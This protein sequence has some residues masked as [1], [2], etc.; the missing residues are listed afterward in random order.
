MSFLLL[1]LVS[2]GGLAADRPN[3]LFIVT[4][5]QA[6]WATGV[7]DPHHNA[8]TPHMDRLMRTGARLTNVHADTPVCSPARTTLMTGQYGSEFGI[9]DWIHPR[10]EKELGVPPDVVMWPELLQEAG[11]Y[12]GLVGKWHLGI[13]DRHHPTNNGFDYFM[14]H[15]AGGWSTEDPRLE[16]N[17]EYQ[18]FKGLNTD[19]L[20]DHVMNF[21][22]RADKKDAPFLM[23]WHKRAPPG[24]WLP[25]S[26]ADW[27]PY[28]DPYDPVIPNPDYP[29]LDVERV[30][31]S[32][33]EYLASVRGVDR[34]M[35]RVMDLLE[36]RGM[37]ENTVVIFLS[38]HGYNVGHH[39]IFYKGNAFWMLNEVPPSATENVPD[40]RRPNMWDTSLQ[41]PAA[42]R[43]PGVI[44]PGSRVEETITFLDFFSTLLAIANADH[45]EDATDR[46]RIFLPLLKGKKVPDWDNSFYGEY[47][48]HHGANTHMRMYRT[49]RWKLVRD[50]LNPERD[51]LYD[52]RND[53]KETNNLIDSRRGTV[54]DAIER[55]HRKIIERMKTI[56]D[57]ALEHVENR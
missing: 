31:R 32:T 30:K 50:V 38:D 56:D 44:E 37:K 18:D 12:T 15:R 24:S 8:I 27:A 40:K 29:H 43:W 26:D 35:G 33:R 51:E 25:V 55:L 57:P 17:G 47:S 9:T 13:Q 36:K 42:V 34:N 20:G 21:L 39:G 46:G 5:D 28:A 23:C 48:M 6:E 19:I 52:L 1:L 10:K 22:T 3:I 45:P 2:S 49:K 16:N 7:T 11:Y 4:D 41:V 54:R 14:G 53:P